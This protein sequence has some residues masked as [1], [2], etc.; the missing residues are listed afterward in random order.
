LEKE[1]YWIKIFIVMLDDDIN[2]RVLK[3]R[4]LQLVYIL[5]IILL[6]GIFLKIA[7]SLKELFLSFAV[8]LLFNYFL[9]K[10]IDLLTKYIRSRFMAVFIVYMSF[11]VGLGF[12]LSLLIP[13]LTLQSSVLQNSLPNFH[14][15]LN[16]FLIELKS[17]L[18]NYNINLSINTEAKN[19]D[20]LASN[21]GSIIPQIETLQIS[22]ITSF[23]VSSSMSAAVY[24]ILTFILSFYLLVDGKRAWD[25]FLKSFPARMKFHLECIKIKVDRCLFALLI[26]QVEIASLTTIVMLI[27]YLALNIPYGL[28]L[29]L[30][31][32]LEIIP[33]VGTW[34]AIVPCII[35]ILFTS[36]VSKGLIAFAIY[37]FYTQ[38]IRDNFIAP[39]IMGSNLGYHPLSIIFAMVI[40]AQFGGIAGII[41]ALPV[42]AVF[43]SFIEYNAELNSLKIS[44]ADYGED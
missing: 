12:L 16:L 37:L 34:T 28:L 21:L 36:G 5:L 29:G 26:G 30:V 9:T 6:L 8:A 13:A 1:K 43:V 44:R 11:L 15:N 32:M 33:V 40:G 23:I 24:F 41:I 35:I 2:A 25:L 3:N 27:T 19:M 31:Q 20:E 14:T 7:T 38:I 39:K 10:P 4:I 17:Q 42:L 18:A 22:K